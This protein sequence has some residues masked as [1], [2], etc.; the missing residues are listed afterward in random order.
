MAVWCSS[1]R[2]WSFP[3]PT[4]L[5]P[6]RSRVR[7]GERGGSSEPFV[8]SCESLPPLYRA[9]R[10][11][12]TSLVLGWAPDQ[13]A[14]S[15]DQLAQRPTGGDQFHHL[16]DNIKGYYLFTCHKWPYSVIVRRGCATREVTS[17][18]HLRC[19][20]CI[21]CVK[22]VWILDVEMVYCAIASVTAH[23]QVL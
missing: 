13:G 17:L 8:S 10:R 6:D 5:P 1:R 9:V 11:G 19:T 21:F 20:F 12:P 14:R 2:R 7:G 15:R 4:A 23:N 16:K 3:S 22:Q 18:N